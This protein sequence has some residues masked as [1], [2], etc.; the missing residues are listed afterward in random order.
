MTRLQKLPVLLGLAA[1]FACLVWL[2]IDRPAAVPSPVENPIQ[3]PES[4]EEGVRALADPS[5]R[6]PVGVSGFAVRVLDAITGNAVSAARISYVTETGVDE[7]E[8]L[9]DAQGIAA[10]SAGAMS[11]R[12]VRATGYLPAL[13]ELAL[14]DGSEILLEPAATLEL[15]F[16]SDDGAPVSGIEALLLPPLVEGPD[17]D[18]GHP[19]FGCFQT[20]F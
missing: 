4:H 8:A 13:E 9:T 16:V 19:A 6:A 1:V 20:A 15:H 11:S 17:W 14:E 10:L 18:S 7:I 3:S 2:A 5:R 12:E